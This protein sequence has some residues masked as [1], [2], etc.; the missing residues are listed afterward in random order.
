MKKTVLILM[1]VIIL[2]VLTGCVAGS[3]QLRNT[4][5]EESKP[6]G[7]WHGL[8]HGFISP[9]TFI[10][11]LFNKSVNIYEVHNSGSWYNFGF[12]LGIM[13]MFSG[14]GRAGCRAFRD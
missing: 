4:A 10:I 14:S 6:A 9:V 2:I 1:C 7:F 13:C 8:L 11:S 5:R 3:N 12:M